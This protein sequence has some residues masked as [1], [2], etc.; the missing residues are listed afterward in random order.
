MTICRSVRFKAAISAA[1][2]RERLRRE[3][4]ERMRRDACPAH[5]F[6]RVEAEPPSWYCPNCNSPAGLDY[7]RGFVS[8]L[9]AT[10]A[11]PA[12]FVADYGA[13]P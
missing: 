13:W 7:L 9:I 10:G 1:A 11:D 4:E 2:A 12:A 6:V 8:G 3:L 5:R